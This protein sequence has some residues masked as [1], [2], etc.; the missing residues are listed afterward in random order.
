MKIKKLILPLLTAGMLLSGLVIGGVG[1]A[2]DDDD[3]RGERHERHEKH[4]RGGRYAV[5]ENAVYKQECS[6]C[7]FLYLSGLLPAKSWEAMMQGTDKH[8]GEN[9]GLDEKSKNEILSFLTANSAEKTNTKWANKIVRSSG[10]TAPTKITEVPW[11]AK[12][13][14][15]IKPEVF[16]R[17]SIGSR[18]NC[19]ACH[20]NAG[21]GD[22]EEDSVSIP[23]Q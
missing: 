9:L 6:S 16:K 12:E 15:R 21:Q 4:E 7:H 22:F 19:G 13:H 11:I 5:V 18:S 20:P 14:R 1:F 17:A 2:D 3:E 8:F 23:K 10:S